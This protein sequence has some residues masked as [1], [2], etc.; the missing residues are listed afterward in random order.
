MKLIN[1]SAHLL[2]IMLLWP[3][4]AYSQNYQE[5]GEPFV[6]KYYNIK[7]GE[8]LYKIARSFNLGID[9]ILQ[10][11]PD[12]SDPNFLLA[13]KK[14]ILPTARLIP[15]VKQEGIVIN[16][17]ELRLYFF[18]DEETKTFPISIGRDERTPI[19]K[20]KIIE[21]RQNPFWIPPLSI[22]LE[23][24]KLPEIVPPGPENPLGNY[25][26]YLDSSHNFNFQRIII[27]GT[28]APW[29]IGSRVSHGCIRLYPENIEELFDK[30]EIG[31]K[32]EIINQPLKI[33][34]SG[35]KI[36]LEVHLRENPDLETGNPDVIELIC[37]KI[38]DC[39]RRIN[40]QK[41]ND[42]M[43]QNL[44]IP[45]EINNILY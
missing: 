23:N 39:E 20:T 10:A 15:D 41:V 32:V 37:Q 14:I 25:A 13:E 44:G 31:T 42:A 7:K 26:L 30:V 38:K 34:D 5:E 27:H 2:F 6:A 8:T 4:A 12:L 24:P 17:S 35:N 19:G 9:E 11:N 43:I 18:S 16:L 1:L 21:K 22:R 3:G 40:W 33:F 28:N 45:T 29:T 36:Y